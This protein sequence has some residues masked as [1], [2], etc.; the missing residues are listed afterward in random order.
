M[1]RKGFTKDRRGRLVRTVEEVPEPIAEPVV[2]VV[3]QTTDLDSLTFNELRALC[4]ERG[5]DAKGKKAEL[6]A[7]LS[8]SGDGESGE[9]SE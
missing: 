8:D 7:K 3:D 4:K 6:I 2:E 1:V 9:E 5:L